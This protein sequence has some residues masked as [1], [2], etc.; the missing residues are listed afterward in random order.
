ML[1]NW[2]DWKADKFLKAT[3]EMHIAIVQAL[4]DVRSKT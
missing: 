3:K 4:I 1:N 2:M